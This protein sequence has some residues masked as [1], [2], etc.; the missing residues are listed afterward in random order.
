VLNPRGLTRSGRRGRPAS[1]ER[2]AVLP[3]LA[4]TRNARKGAA[5][6]TM[7]TRP[8]CGLQSGAEAGGS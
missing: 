1:R 5:G 4:Q 6:R 2:R 8:L 7:A 3:R